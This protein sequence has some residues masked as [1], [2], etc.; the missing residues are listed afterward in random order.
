MSSRAS[1]NLSLWEEEQPALVGSGR[2]R[3]NWSYSRRETF[4]QCLRRYFYQYYATCATDPK[5]REDLRR[6]K[7]IKNRHLRV[8]D[9]VHL[10]ISTYFKK[11]KQGKD[12]PS[13]WLQNWVRKLFAEDQAYSRLIRSGGAP[14]TAQYPPTVLDE[15]LYEV[16]NSTQ[17]LEAANQQLGTAVQSFFS[18]SA[19]AEFRV[20]GARP[21]SLIEHKMS[22]SGYPAPVS[23]KL[24]L[25]VR[26]GSSITIVDWKLGSFSD[27]G[28]ESLQLATY[29]LWA[30]ATYDIPVD[31][32]R[33]AKAHLADGTVV[34]FRADSEAFANARVRI[35]QDLER[36]I[37]LHT[38]G[39][40]GTMEAFTPAPHPKVC[41]LCPFRHVCPEGAKSDA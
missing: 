31:A 9:L 27:G 33:I 38:Y 35:H 15:L 5:L 24:D 17:L 8:G 34:D 40:T 19:F 29:G 32:I 7:E 22:L 26:D 30:R 6:I 14:S 37:F 39:Q 25:A 4:D 20:L 2:A 12:L 23:G 28:A 16:H 36:M 41:R 21:Q 10:A 13:S 1:A 3:L 11:L 18:T